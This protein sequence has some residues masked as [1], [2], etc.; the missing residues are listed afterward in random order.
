MT[1]HK[2]FEF[3]VNEDDDIPYEPVEPESEMPEVDAFDALMYGQ[4]ISAEV[5]LLKGDISVSTNVI[6][7]KH[8]RDG[9][10]LHIFL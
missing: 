9:N 1:R 7:R 10:L 4:Y 8:D 3:I 6:G 2:P 5:L